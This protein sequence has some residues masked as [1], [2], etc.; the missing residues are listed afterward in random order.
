MCFFFVH[1]FSDLV[2]SELE[3]K[4]FLKTLTRR[5]FVEPETQTTDYHEE[6]C[7]EG[8]K[9]E[10]VAEYCGYSNKNNW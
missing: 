3:A 10:E 9:V 5:K 7:H 8:C 4:S 6:C 2:K 1:L